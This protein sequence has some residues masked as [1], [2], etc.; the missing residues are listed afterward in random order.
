MRKIDDIFMKLKKNSTD[1]HFLEILNPDP[2]VEFE[3]IRIRKS[4][5]HR[6]FLK[7]YMEE[8]LNF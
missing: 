3:F 1:V 8:A 2:G 5:F 4:H 7:K 6:E